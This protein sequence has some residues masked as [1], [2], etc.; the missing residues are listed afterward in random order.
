MKSGLKKIGQSLFSFCFIIMIIGS[1]HLFM[2]TIEHFDMKISVREYAHPGRKGGWHGDVSQRVEIQK[3]IDKRVASGEEKEREI[4]QKAQLSLDK[5]DGFD[6]N[7]LPV[8]AFWVMCTLVSSMLALLLLV[9][10]RFTKNNVLQTLMGIFAGFCAWFTVELGLTMAARQLGVAKRFDIYNSMIIGTHGEFVLLKYSWVFLVPV[11]LYLLFQESVRCNMFV[12]LRRQFN[13]MRGAVATGRIDN[14][15]PR[16]AFF[17]SSAV[18]FFYVVL[19]LAFD[20][21]IFGATSWFTFLVFFI[22][23]SCSGYLFY[24]LLKQASFGANLRY[25]IGVALVFWTD[26]EILEKW[27]AMKGPWLTYQPH[28][29]VIFITALLLG[30]VMIVRET[31]RS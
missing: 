27:G 11:L 24:R 5:G 19:L 2:I 3:M 16:V 1:G 22:C 15:A 23:F 12:F 18:W 17:F 29:V 10:S 30:G 14:Y 8:S 31:R 4:F 13:L 20:E 9:F 7:M 26:I 28:T 21:R 6:F 25:A